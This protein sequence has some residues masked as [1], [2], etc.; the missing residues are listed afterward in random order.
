MAGRR[1]APDNAG[2]VE[3]GEVGTVELTKM[4]E[5]KRP[6]GRSHHLKLN[7]RVPGCAGVGSRMFNQDSEDAKSTLEELLVKHRDVTLMLPRPHG[8]GSITS[9]VRIQ[10]GVTSAELSLI[11]WPTADS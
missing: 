10:L 5:D 8:R 6:I 3:L 2:A 11:G 7:Q 4:S 1:Q 9:T